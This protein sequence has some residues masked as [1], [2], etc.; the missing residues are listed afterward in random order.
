MVMVPA[1]LLMTWLGAC[2]ARDVCEGGSMLEGD[3]GLIVTQ[4]EHGVGWQQ[5][6]CFAC[7]VE[8]VLHQTGCTPDVDLER[9]QAEV[10]VHGLSSCGGCHGGNGHEE[11]SEAV[12]D[13]GE[14]TP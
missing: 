7:H 3:Q 6:D 2:G 13:T 1:I 8:A 14:E 9:L 11:G 10:E 4:A 5:A 12:G